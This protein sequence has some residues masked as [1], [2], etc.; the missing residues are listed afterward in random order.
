MNLRSLLRTDYLGAGASA[1][2]HLSSSLGI[3][4]P[5]QLT[6]ELCEPTGNSQ[7]EAFI[8]SGNQRRWKYLRVVM[9]ATALGAGLWL[10]G[11]CYVLLRTP[12]LPDLGL[13]TAAPPVRPQAPTLLVHVPGL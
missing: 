10:G 4:S 13:R 12:A 3:D 9:A 11:A 6:S 5:S 7:P 2:D 1:G 8:F